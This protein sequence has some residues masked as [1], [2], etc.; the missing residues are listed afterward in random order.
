MC[1]ALLHSVSKDL[2]ESIVHF[3]IVASFYYKIDIVDLSNS[4]D[5]SLFYILKQI[6]IVKGV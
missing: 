5:V 3:N 4:I 2:I 6:Y 1:V